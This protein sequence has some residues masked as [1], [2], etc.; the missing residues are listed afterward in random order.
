MAKLAAKLDFIGDKARPLSDY[1]YY[2][3]ST[4]NF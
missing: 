4:V 3:I 2:P 1:R